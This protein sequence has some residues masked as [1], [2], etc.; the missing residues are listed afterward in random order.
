[1]N[2]Q[3][4]VERKKLEDPT[5]DRGDLEWIHSGPWNKCY[6]SPSQMCLDYVLEKWGL[7]RQVTSPGL[8]MALQYL[9]RNAVGVGTLAQSLAAYDPQFS[10]SGHKVLRLSETWQNLLSY[11]LEV[12]NV[13][14]TVLLGQYI[15]QRGLYMARSKP[16]DFNSLRAIGRVTIERLLASGTNIKARMGTEDE[17]FP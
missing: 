13:D 14:P 1:M 3:R 7:T 4:E 8:L 11:V 16:F 5:P 12:L 15:L 6:W 9:L 2:P 10:V 17:D